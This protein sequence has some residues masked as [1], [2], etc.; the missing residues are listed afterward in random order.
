MAKRKNVGKPFEDEVREALDR[1]DAYS[2]RLYDPPPYLKGIANPCDIIAYREGVFYML[3]CK[4]VHGNRLPIFS[5]D[6]KGEHIYGNVSNAQ[7]TG[8]TKASRHGIVAGLLVWWVDRD[9]TKFIPIQTAQQIRD[10]GEKSIRYDVT[11]EGIFEVSGNKRRVY[12]DY[13]FQ[14]FFD[15]YYSIYNKVYPYKGRT[16]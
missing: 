9:V 13:D 15:T 10:S 2:L 7:W 1:T 4:S 8:L 5:N 6:P 12:Y 11:G 3:E 14:P 16:I